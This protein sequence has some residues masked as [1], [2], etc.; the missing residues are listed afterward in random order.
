MLNFSYQEKVWAYKWWRV[1]EYRHD[2]RTKGL[3][4]DS[5]NI[6]FHSD[7]KGLDW[8]ENGTIIVR[9]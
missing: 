5:L 7:L 1:L 8:F 3:K 4:F 2:I 6:V 9:A